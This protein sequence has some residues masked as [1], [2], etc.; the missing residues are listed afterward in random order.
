ML[1]L[2]YQPQW[3]S[4]LSFFGIA[5][6]MALT[7]YV[8]QAAAL[9][10]LACGYGVALRIRP[11]YEIPAAIILFSV[12]AALS[13]AWLARFRYGPLERIWRWIT[14]AEWSARPALGVTT[15]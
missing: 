2:A 15:G 10:V 13:N 14:Y 11:Y 5:G 7:N 4:R 1:L 8:V 12:C 3:K 9:S 6:R